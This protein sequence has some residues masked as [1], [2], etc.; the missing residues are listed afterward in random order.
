MYRRSTTCSPSDVE[1]DSPHPW[2]VLRRRPFLVVMGGELVSMVGD[3]IYLIALTWLILTESTP[4]VLAISLI[5]AVVPRAV[6]MLVGGALTDRL[7]ARLVMFCSHA[8]RGLMVL[9]LALTASWGTLQVWHFLAISAAFGIADAFFWPAS[10]TI[11][12][13]L[14]PSDEL[15]QANAVSQLGE[16]SA[17]LAGPALGG[18]LVA[19]VGPTPALVVNALTF[20]V[21][22]ATIWWAP[23][24]TTTRPDR[25]A[26]S[27]RGTFSEIAEGLS[28]ARRKP[29]VR[30]V[31]I[32]ISAAALS[33]SGLFGVGL[34][35]LA[36]TFSQSAFAL[37]LMISCWGL[38]QFLGAASAGFTGLP[39]RWGLLI[40]AM[41][42]VEGL[43]FAV[44]GVIP[45]LWLVAPLFVVL[46][47]GVAYTTDVALPAWIQT[48]TPESMLGRVNS[49]IDVP[50]MVFEPLSII[51]MGVLVSI[52]LQLALVAAAVPMLTAAVV[53]SFTPTARQMGGAAAVQAGP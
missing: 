51:V 17:S 29:G 12:P 19:I 6:L 9:A 24:P 26:L 35:A 41:A 28:Y 46:G 39:L 43:S 18:L 45:S 2:Q 20:V 3:S 22:A 13:T 38:G 23:R 48:T 1:G 36:Q 4:T 52:D 27:V 15:V 8:S 44:L 25:A 33:Y 34:P 5:C 21:A 49:V 14:V 31:L 16:Q 47:F 11:L 32:A 42:Y 50:R 40:I 53:L 37:G 10:K 7:S 30:V